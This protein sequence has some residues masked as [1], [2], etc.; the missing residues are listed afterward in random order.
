MERGFGPTRTQRANLHLALA[1]AFLEQVW[2]HRGGHGREQG[3]D[4]GLRGGAAGQEVS[5]EAP[6]R[7]P[8]PRR[9]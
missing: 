1:A 7:V 3:G 5:A 8:P 4:E 6:H 9:V 2:C